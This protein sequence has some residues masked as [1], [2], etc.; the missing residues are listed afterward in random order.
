MDIKKRVVAILQPFE[1]VVFALIFGSQANGSATALSDVDIAV[2]TNKSCDLLREGEMIANLE[3]ALNKKVD[4]VILNDLYKT[5]AR[6]CYNIVENHEVLINKDNSAYVDFKTQT[7]KYY[8]DQKHMY[9]MFD[10]ALKKRLQDGNFGKT[11][12]S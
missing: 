3:A 7:L 10:N 4:L 9:E 1:E 2:Y 8:L 12:A 5:N 11:Q 6:L